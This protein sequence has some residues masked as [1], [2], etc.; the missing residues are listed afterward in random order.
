MRD[1]FYFVQKIGNK[2]VPNLNASM[3]KTV[4][5]SGIQSIFNID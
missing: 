3:I 4:R 2:F 5:K 1:I